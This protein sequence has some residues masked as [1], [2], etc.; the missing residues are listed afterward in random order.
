MSQREK[1]EKVMEITDKMRN[2]AHVENK[3]YNRCMKESNQQQ[4]S[5]YARCDKR[6]GSD[7]CY[8]RADRNAKSR[9]S[10]CERVAHSDNVRDTVNKD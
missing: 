10:G 1:S 7:K 9:S 4:R 5:D 8:D 2:L 3:D 6:G